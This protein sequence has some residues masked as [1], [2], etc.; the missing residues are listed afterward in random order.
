MSKSASQ[1]GRRSFARAG[2]LVT[3][4]I[5]F[6]APSYASTAVYVGKNLTEDGSVLLAGFGDERSSHWLSIVPAQEH[7]PG[8]TVRVG[9]T[10]SADLPGEL[11]DIPQAARTYRYIS[12]DYSYFAGFP[13]PLTNG[14]MNEHG[15]A[16]RDVALPSRRELVEM[17]PALQH[18]PNYSDLARIA[19]ERARTAREAV[20]V[21][22]EI[23][24]THG[25]TT[26]G[27]NSHV[28]ADANEGWVMLEFAGGKGLWVARR[29]GPDDVWLNWRGYHGFG[30]IQELPAN[31]RSNPD[32]LASE[33][34]IS[35][36]TE[37]GWYE[38]RAG[39]PFDVIEVYALPKEDPDGPY[40]RHVESSL[41]QA[42]P[43]VTVRLL[44]DLLHGAGRDTSGYGQVAHL[45]S[46]VD[47]D[48]LTLW[49]APGPPHTAPF[50]PWRIG[51]ESVP[52]EYRRHRYLTEGEARRKVDPVQRGLES[53]RYAFRA[54]TRLEYLVEEHPDAFLP[55]VTAMLEAY[56]ARLLAA[57]PGVE[58]TAEILRKAGD[59]ALARRYLTEQAHEAAANGMDLL[60]TLAE[61]LEL[62][63]RLLHGI[64]TPEQTQP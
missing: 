57:Q 43:G 42:A 23:I 15:L 46:G 4:A 22:S 63:T 45:R 12:M 25:Y 21:L 1:S 50:I 59:R 10:A 34:F 16:V 29:L 49:V 8:S 7:A 2:F 27:G 19:L 61:Y 35:F 36:A 30:Y 18:G 39:A 38:P 28:F 52:P 14:G 26:Y 20:Q 58:R 3:L 44:M 6:G 11:I 54:V 56:E 17:T 37:Q 51:V 47:P 9:A 32:Y 55:E 40:A 5:S 53:T 24:D 64:R 31:W 33:N 13:A 60:D 62:K 48:L 41:R